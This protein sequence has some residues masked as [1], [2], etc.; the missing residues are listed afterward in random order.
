VKQFTQLLKQHCE[1]S[2][3]KKIA[4][5]DAA[6]IS[7][8]YLYCVLTE[9]RNPSDQVVYNLA[10][11]LRLTD[12]QTGELLTAA[13]HAPSVTLLQMSSALHGTVPLPLLDDSRA[14]HLAQRWYRLAQ[15]IP[16]VLQAPL[17]SEMEKLLDYARYK[18]LLCGGATLAN[19]RFVDHTTDMHRGGELLLAHLETFNTIVTLVG[20]LSDKNDEQAAAL[21]MHEDKS[22]SPPHVV[23][24]LSSIDQLTGSV[25]AGELSAASYQPRLVEQIRETLRSGV[26]WEIRRRI[27]EALPGICKFDA[28]GA[29]QTIELLRLDRDDKYGVDIRRRVI[30]ALVFLFDADSTFL[31]RIVEL[32]RPQ[33]GDDFYVSSAIMEACGD[34]QTRIKQP[35]RRNAGGVAGETSLA[36][37]LP[38][39]LAE[40]LKIQRQLLMMWEGTELECLQYSLALY[41]FLCA[42]DAMLLSVREG[43]QSSEKRMQ[44]VAARYLERVLPLKPME[45]LQVYKFVLQEASS[46]NVRRTVARAM[47]S[48]LRCMNESSLPI[49]T[50]AQTIIITLAQ[51]SDVHIRRTVADYAMQLLHVNREFL[52]TILR[53]LHQDRD[54]AIRHRLQPVT[55]RLAEVWLRWYAET[56]GLVHTTRRRTATPFGE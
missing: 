6:H 54:Q 1:S 5:A 22:Q 32:L 29:F 49:R 11:A 40:I 38:A 36:R 3:M 23:D 44:L 51:D 16:E 20:E 10:K 34:L 45:T 43:L 46:R 24:M 47:P 37:P 9:T 50:M 52:L 18:Y 41:D 39:E 31:P 14:A 25:L 26:P 13:G 12:E 35:Q 17:L 55:L 53:Y 2:G 33:T 7:Y 30:E 56:A 21:P 4:I 48:L 19:L 27:T 42:P 8:T 15:E 28:S